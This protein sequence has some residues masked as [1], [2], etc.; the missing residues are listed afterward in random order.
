MRLTKSTLG[1]AN[2][3]KTAATRALCVV[4]AGLWT[5]ARGILE[6]TDVD[7]QRQKA[8][9]SRLGPRCGCLSW[10]GL[11][12][13]R[14]KRM[15]HGKTKCGLAVSFLLLS[16]ASVQGFPYL[17]PSSLATLY[18]APAAY[19]GNLSFVLGERD[20]FLP[21][22]HI[23]QWGIEK[24]LPATIDCLG[25]CHDGKWQVANAY[26]TVAV[27]DDTV[28][29]KQDSRADNFGCR[30]F[31]LL[32]E[33]ND[34]LTYP[35]FLSGL[36]PFAYRPFLADSQTLVVKATQEVEEARHGT[37]CRPLDINLAAT[38][39]GLSFLNPVAEQVLFYQ[40]MT[41][42]SRG[43]HFTGF[44][45]FT[46]PSEYGVNDSVDVLGFPSLRVHEGPVAYSIDVLPRV[47]ALIANG[48]ESLDKDLRNWKL[49]GLYI[50]SATNGEAQIVSH[51]SAIRLFGAIK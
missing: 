41:Y 31:D 6:P 13:R 49:G 51:H 15:G 20:N 29:L 42:D 27:T 1:N 32:L 16:C 3:S 8:T 44:W 9:I 22:W 46:G 45:F 48:P 36:L 7:C 12:L 24:E 38:V 4:A 2:S 39:I 25:N 26:A 23:A 35:Y 11:W 34:S 40:L 5:V 18:T 43:A 17:Y 19:T 50:G 33:P 21:S 47:Q 10:C 14:K 30:E 28:T 37:R